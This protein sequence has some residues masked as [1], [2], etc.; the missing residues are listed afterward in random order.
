MLR[1]TR[2]VNLS[3]VALC[4]MVAHSASAQTTTPV[5][6]TALTAYSWSSG[7]VQQN[8]GGY[9]AGSAL[10][11]STGSAWQWIGG[12]SFSSSSN[13]EV[14][15]ALRQAALNSGTLTIDATFD[16][17]AFTS[18]DLQWLGITTNQQC[19]AGNWVQTNVGYAS[20]P[21]TVPQPQT[22][23]MQILPTSSSVTPP[24][25][26]NPPKLYVDPSLATIS[27]GFGVNT[28]SA[29]QG[30]FV[31]SSMSVTAVPEPGTWAMLAA[32]GVAGIAG[33][34]RRRFGG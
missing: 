15:E 1:F 30:G 3:A 18:T 14:Y 22:F 33:V 25:F 17:A 21:V 20:T 31:I 11:R 5:P 19:G 4:A 7:I 6:L 27:F 32:A 13:P 28:N 26:T 16:P 2:F 34:R 29:T 9:P 8:P 10:L 23:T 24:D 12:M